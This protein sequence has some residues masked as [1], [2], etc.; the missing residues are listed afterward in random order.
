MKPNFASSFLRHVAA[1]CVFVCALPAAA[2]TQV[3]YDSAQAPNSAYT[4]IAPGWLSSVFVN[5]Q[6]SVGSDGTTVSPNISAPLNLGARGGYA[7][8]FVSGGLVNPLFPVLDRNAGFTLS[9]GFRLL[10]ED[11]SL[12]ANRA[13][14]SVIL[15]DSAHRGVEI[16]FQNDRIFAQR[17]GANL[18]T[19]GEFN[20]AAAPSAFAFNRWDLNIGAAGYSLTR[21]DPGGA[22]PIL[23]GALRDYSSV[24]LPASLAYGASNYLFVGDNTISAG[25]VFTLNYLAIATAP[26]PEPSTYGM[27]LAGFA[28]VAAV[29]QRRRRLPGVCRMPRMHR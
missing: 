15:L 21:A 26:V 5:A 29:A 20:D 16:G 24:G 13:G 17:D 28:L 8:Q 23:S 9:F 14:F 25:A 3:L 19:A 2:A 11:H 10:Q 18:F 4:P 22:I 1:A 12:N 6:E 7:N 27:L